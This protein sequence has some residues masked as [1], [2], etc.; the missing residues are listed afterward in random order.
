[1]VYLSAI[2]LLTP[3]HAE[4]AGDA[5]K[6]TYDF[7]TIVQEI[8]G[9][10]NNVYMDGTIPYAPYAPKF[11]LTDQ[12]LSPLD[13]ADYV[14]TTDRQYGPDNLTPDNEVFFLFKK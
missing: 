3:W 9:T 13:I 10:G 14:V 4:R 8:Q 12:F 5:S 2:S 6:Y 7:N 11:Y 1:M